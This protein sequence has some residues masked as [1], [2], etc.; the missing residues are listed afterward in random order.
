MRFRVKYHEFHQGFQEVW[1]REPRV[2]R[3]PRV[4][5]RFSRGLEQKTMG[6]I[7][8]FWTSGVENHVFYQ[9]FPDVLS[10]K[11]RVLSRFSGGLE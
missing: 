8:A 1:S 9:V 2:L 3:E 4:F 5:S 10:R 11:A 6:F 7:E